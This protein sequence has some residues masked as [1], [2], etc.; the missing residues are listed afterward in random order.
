MAALVSGGG[1]NRATGNPALLRR[2][3]QDTLDLI[4]F[5]NGPVTSPSG[6]LRARVGHPKPF[7]LRIKETS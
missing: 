2:H 5:A 7:G 1:Q 6:K 4:E 3:I